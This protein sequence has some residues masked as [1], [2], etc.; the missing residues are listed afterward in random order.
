VVGTK[1]EYAEVGRK[2]RGIIPKYSVAQICS[3]FFMSSLPEK[4]GLGRVLG[5][6]YSEWIYAKLY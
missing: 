6:Y 4:A 1:E 2:L 5:I 3:T